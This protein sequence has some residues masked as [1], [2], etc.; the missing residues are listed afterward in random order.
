MCAD[1]DDFVRQCAAPRQY[2]DD[3]LR[4]R[5]HRMQVDAAFG[6]RILQRE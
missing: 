4:F 2:A 6:A 1:D 5:D 3:V